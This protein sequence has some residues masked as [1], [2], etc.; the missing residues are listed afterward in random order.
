MPVAG[1]GGGPSVVIAEDH[2]YRV[3]ERRTA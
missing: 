2:Q 1:D 3:G